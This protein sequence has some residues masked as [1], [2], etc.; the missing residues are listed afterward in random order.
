MKYPLSALFLA[1]LLLVVGS[2]VSARPT[3]YIPSDTLALY[4]QLNSPHPLADTTR[5]RLLHELCY[6]LREDQPLRAMYYGEQGLTLARR[7]AQQP[8]LLQSLLALA[9]CQANLSNGPRALKLLTEAQT[10]ANATHDTDALVRAYSTQ[11]SIYHER[12]DS[13]IAWQHYHRALLLARRPAVRQVT[14]MKL[15][16]NVSSLLFFRQQYQRALHFDS[17]ALAL[18]RQSGDRTAESLYLTSLGRYH[19]QLRHLAQANQ[20]LRQALAI[21]RQQRALRQQAS[22]LEMLAL[23]YIETDQPART[24]SATHAALRVARHCNFLE[25]VLDAYN[26]LGA[27]AADQGRYKAAYDWNCQYLALNDTLNNRQ[28]MLTLAASQASAD[29]QERERRIHL[30]VEKQRLDVLR[31]RI[32]GGAVGILILALLASGYFYNRL[33]R[34]RMAL[35][36]SHT[37]LETAT[38]ELRGMTAFKDKLYAIIAHDLR[39]PVTAF[40]GVTGMIDVY[41]RDG[42][43][44]GLAALPGIV[45]QAADSLNRLLDNVLNWAV[46]QTGELNYRPE[47]LLVNDMLQECLALYQT[48]AEAGGQ[49]LRAECPPNLRMLADRNMVRTILRNLVGNALKFNPRGGFVHLEASADPANLT[50][51]LL[52]C[53]DNG[54]GMDPDLMAHLRHNQAVEASESSFWSGGTASGLGLGLVLCRAFVHRHGGVLGIQSRQG[55]GTSITATLPIAEEEAPGSAIFAA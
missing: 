49:H 33:R 45:R 30:L 28:T 11:G 44:A 5:L 20:L 2:P 36:A 52:S 34:N 19:L 48:T 12:G 27:E 38:Q 51:V 17:L 31:N 15:L 4:Q 23:Y 35:A 22:Q 1:L 43:Q 39:G 25:R 26:I 9:T 24:D 13:A 53:T 7:T 18:A 47:T 8:A 16:G 40:A 46:S 54:P 32:L 50:R 41:L 42:N 29:N 21:S 55:A 6:A 10:L 3:S 37:A 14:R